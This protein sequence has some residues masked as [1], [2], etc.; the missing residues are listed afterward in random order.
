MKQM[1]KNFCKDMYY[2]NCEERKAFK[3]AVISFDDYF[4]INEDFLLDKF[5]EVCDTVYS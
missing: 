5:R 4:R 3:D 1:F 2:R